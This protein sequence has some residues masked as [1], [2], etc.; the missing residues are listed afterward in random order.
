MLNLPQRNSLVSQTAAFLRDEINRGGW[1]EWLPSERTLCESLQV[2]RNTLRAA[3]GQLKREGIID[4]KHGAG[5]RISARPTKPKS[6]TLRS[7]DVAF[8][9]P[10]PLEQLRPTQTL[11]IDEMRAMLSE[12]GCR[13]HVFH[14]LQ[15]FRT[16]PGPALQKLV[17]QN[18]H[19]C[20]ILMLSN[21]KTQR[22][23]EQ[24][25]IPSVVAGSVYSGIDLPFRDL[26]H[27]AM[28]RHAAGVM[29]GAGHRKVAL[30]IQKSRRA[31][32]LESE[33]GFIEGVRQSPHTDAEVVI[34]NQEP[35][36][37]GLCNTLRR[38][39]EQKPPPTAL[40][41]ANPHYFLTVVT[42]LGQMGWRVPHDISVLSRDDE[43]F[44]SFVVPEPGR[45]LTSPYTL[46]KSLLRPVLEQL[47]G[48][49]VTHRAI[50]IMPDFIRGDSLAA[51]GDK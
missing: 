1:N 24:N 23:F 36:V 25:R 46:A 5:N 4:P 21:E 32:D 27:K 18:P 38:L 16:N 9:T 11:W 20:W 8:L 35:T 14:G 33:A 22:W 10:S 51:P 50:R 42:R 28:C 2:S 49:V 12:R 6:G 37:A 7:H 43:P 26:D 31:G 41:V 17:R 15:Y 45:Y 29:L 47:E 3:L 34:G 44:L 13:L 30:L 39:M 48:G 19:A 40:L